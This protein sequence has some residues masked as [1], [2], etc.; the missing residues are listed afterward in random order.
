MHRICHHKCRIKT[1][2]EMT[3]N[4]IVICLV[5]VFLNEICRT[6]KS[7]LVDILLHLVRCHA[8]SGINKFE[9]FLLW[10]DNDMDILLDI[11]RILILSHHLQFFQFGD[12]VTAVWDQLS[13]KDIVVW[14][15]PLLDN[16][17]NIFAVDGQASALLCHKNHIPFSYL[18]IVYIK[19]VALSVR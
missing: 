19:V 17:K 5:L 15:Q 16:W 1:K 18:F 6:W 7:D 13:V 11:W 3:D 12:G 14:I 8:K 4:L 9:C 10:I 2:S